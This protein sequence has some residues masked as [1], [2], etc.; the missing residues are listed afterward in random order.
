M[1]IRNNTPSFGMA[2]RKPDAKTMNALRE[3]VTPAQLEAFIKEQSKSK[4][5]DIATTLDSSTGTEVPRFTI[6]AK[7]GVDT[8]GRD[9]HVSVLATDYSDTDTYG[10]KLAKAYYDSYKEV[11]DTLE[12]WRYRIVEP[13]LRRVFTLMQN[14]NYKDARKN[15]PE[16]LINPPLRKLGN[17][18]NR[19][20]REIDDA[21]KMSGMFDAQ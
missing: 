12:G 21:Q 5:F 2:L 9:V 11:L 10:F 15:H 18:V 20:E 19:L 17:I 8:M 7:D 16:L 14:L 4:Y 6:V 3:Y 1:E 13:L